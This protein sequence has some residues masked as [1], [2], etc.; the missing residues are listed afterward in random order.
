MSQMKQLALDISMASSPTLSRFFVGPNAAVIDHLRHWVGDGRMQTARTPV[1]T[2]LWGESGS[3]KTHL[4]KAVREALR[5]QGAVVGW[6]DASTLFPP[7]FDERWAAVLMDDVDIYTPLQQA[8]AFNWFVNA[9]SPATGSPRW[10]LGA[11]PLPPADLKLREDLRTRL[12]WGHVFQLQLLDETARRAVLRQ[13]AD[14][15]G[16]FLGDDVMDDM[17]KRFS[18]DLGSLMQLLDMLDGFALRNKRAITIP[19]LKTMLETE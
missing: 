18:R 16:V 13:E 3:G 5:E 11:G 10:V 8:R 19:L 6:M 14:A 7:P 9:T 2:Y 1:P 4:L 15:R 12:G 17:L